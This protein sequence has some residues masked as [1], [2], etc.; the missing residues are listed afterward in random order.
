[1]P[2]TL[3]CSLIC[4]HQALL[5]NFS[6]ELSSFTQ[7]AAETCRRRKPQSQ[8]WSKGGVN[9]KQLSL[10]R[11]HIGSQQEAGD[12]MH[13]KLYA[14]IFC[15]CSHHHIKPQSNPNNLR[16]SLEQ[17]VSC[18]Y[19]QTFYIAVQFQL[20]RGG[21]E[22]G[23]GEQRS[24]VSI[25]IRLRFIPPASTYPKFGFG[26]SLGDTWVLASNETNSCWT[27]LFKSSM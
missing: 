7:S 25:S 11:V 26:P 20:W 13:K 8:T 23:G 3:L 2:I 10:Q 19:K 21:R 15:V 14:T 5:Q 1:M 24:H 16:K 9:H 18:F 6:H 17:S 27:S 12:S 22:R 4:A